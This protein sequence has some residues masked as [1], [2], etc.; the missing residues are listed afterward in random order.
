VGV[1]KANVR[2]GE[3]WGRT[4]TQVTHVFETKLLLIGDGDGRLGGIVGDR[5]GRGRLWSGSKWHPFRG[6]SY[7]HCCVALR[8]GVGVEGRGEGVY[9]IHED[10]NVD[11][12]VVDIKDDDLNLYSR[13]DR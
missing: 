9:Q 5:C 11:D 2:E 10:G 13:G 8:E 3:N 12:S 7:R 4:E 6:L 1:G